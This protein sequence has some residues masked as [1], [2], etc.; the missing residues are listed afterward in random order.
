M[1]RSYG[2]VF[3]SRFCNPSTNAQGTEHGIGRCGSP[4]HSIRALRG[5]KYPLTTRNGAVPARPT[6]EF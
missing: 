3:D 6:G 5:E 1:P 2:V 4:F